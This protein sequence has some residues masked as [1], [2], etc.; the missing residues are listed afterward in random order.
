MLIRKKLGLVNLKPYFQSLGCS[1]KTHVSETTFPCPIASS[2]FYSKERPRPD[3]HDIC[4]KAKAIAQSSGALAALPFALT[5]LSSLTIR[6][7]KSQ[8]VLLNTI[9]T[10]LSREGKRDEFW[11][12]VDTRLLAS[13]RRMSE[14]AAASL[15][16]PELVATILNQFALD[17]ATFDKAFA[18]YKE[19]LQ[20]LPKLPS[21]TTC[22]VHHH[23]NA[24]LK[25]L[26]RNASCKTL[27]ALLKH[28]TAGEIDKD[29][30]FAKFGILVDPI[31]GDESVIPSIKFDCKSVTSILNTVARAPDGSIQL[32]EA[33]WSHF[34][35]KHGIIFDKECYLALLLV[36]RNDLSRILSKEKLNRSYS[37]RKRKINRV[38]QL[39]GSS[40]VE[41]ETSVKFLSVYFEIC[42]NAKMREAIVEFCGQREWTGHRDSRINACIKR[43]LIKDTQ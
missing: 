14:A 29:V 18:F 41:L 8:P 39:I 32:A 15:W 37:W 38:L 17:G 4:I 9:L 27:A 35:S 34:E 23:H 2:R 1:L 28:F 25:C 6:S 20:W 30:P 21:T 33:L 43:A 13:S 36:Y 10:A 16:S 7:E 3:A 31:L 40:G 12:V 42:L 19:A 24:L 5:R 22:V 11:T 26:S